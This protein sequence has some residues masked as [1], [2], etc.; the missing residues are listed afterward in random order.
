MQQPAARDIDYNKVRKKRTLNYY[1]RIDG[2]N[3]L[4]ITVYYKEKYFLH[5]LS[6]P[7]TFVIF[8]TH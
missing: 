6:G 1:G 3:S 5:S 7:A 4:L 2:I 8:V